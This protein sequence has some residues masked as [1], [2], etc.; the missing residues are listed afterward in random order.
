MLRR[1]TEAFIIMVMMMIII[2]MIILESARIM[3]ILFPKWALPAR[4]CLELRLTYIV[5]L[6]IVGPAIQSGL[7]QHNIW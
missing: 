2:I 6:R 7:E 3:I 4:T 5:D 1:L